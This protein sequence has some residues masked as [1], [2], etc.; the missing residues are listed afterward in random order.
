MGSKLAPWVV[1]ATLVPPTSGGDPDA[2]LM[3]ETSVPFI[4]GYANFTDLAISHNGTGYQ[5]R[6]QV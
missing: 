4:K 1:T 3:G 6:Y 5:I 2:R